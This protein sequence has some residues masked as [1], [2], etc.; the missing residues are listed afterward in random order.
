MIQWK[1]ETIIEANIETY[2]VVD[3][4]YENTPDKKHNKIG[5]T[6]ARIF[7]IEAS[8]TLIKVDDRHTRFIYSGQNKGVNW[9]GKIMVKLMGT[10]NNRKVVFDF[11]ERVRGEAIKD[12]D[13]I[14]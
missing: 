8:F 4:E 2:I 7:E 13:S 5:F 11:M 12:Q 3:L 1:E 6:L 10:K 14:A 9:L